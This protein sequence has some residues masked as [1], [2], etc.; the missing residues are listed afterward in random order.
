MLERRILAARTFAMELVKGVPITEYCD[1]NRLTVRERLALFVQVCQ[2]IQHAHQKGIIHRDIKPGNVLVT[3]HD[4]KP[5]PKVIDFGVAKALNARLTDKT[6]YTEHLQVVGTLLYMSPEQAELSGLDVDTRSDIYSLGVLLYELLTGTTPFTNEE[7]DKA[8][9]DEQRRIIREKDPPRASI[10]ISSLGETA[11]P[12]AERRKTD[13]RKLQDSVRGDL[14]CVILKSL[15]KDRTRRYESATSLARDV[16]R[17]LDNQPVEAH[18]P[19]LRY[20]FKKFASRNKASLASVAIVSVA[21]VVGAGVATW[22]AIAANRNAK[23]LKLALADVQQEYFL[24]QVERLLSGDTIEQDRSQLE[25]KLEDWMVE[26]LLGL[27]ENNRANISGALQH[28]QAAKK[29]N[30]RMFIRAFQLYPLLLSG[31]SDEY[32]RQMDALSIGVP[33]DYLDLLFVGNAFAFRDA[34]R[35]L[36]MVKKAISLRNSVYAQK[37]LAEIHHQIAMDENDL[38][39]ANESLKLAEA[40]CLLEPTNRTFRGAATGV[41]DDLLAM[42]AI[43]KI[44]HGWTGARGPRNRKPPA[45]VRGICHWTLYGFVLPRF[46]RRTQ[47]RRRTFQTCSQKRHRLLLCLRCSDALSNRRESQSDRIPAG[48]A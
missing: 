27:K 42:H 8:G 33:K 10:R 2:A 1:R 18:L 15:D 5:V 32:E 14:D 4:G 17:Y 26:F 45:G 31:E 20:R 28:F 48:W 3:L 46:R 34:R 44:E 23:A 9:F 47:T 24:R 37:M 21:L 12:V 40:I 25:S 7:L 36:P 13:P 22:Q 11:T 35:G 38:E 19:T 41:P 6:I 29:L 30:D 39:H 43:A 16:E